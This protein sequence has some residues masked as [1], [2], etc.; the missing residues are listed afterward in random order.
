M[1]RRYVDLPDSERI[2]EANWR[3][4]EQIEQDRLYQEAAYAFDLLETAEALARK[5]EDLDFDD[6]V[7][8]SLREAHHGLVDALRSRADQID[9]DLDLEVNA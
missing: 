5:E 2:T 6:D 3:V 8:R 4:V 1:T 9:E 7:R